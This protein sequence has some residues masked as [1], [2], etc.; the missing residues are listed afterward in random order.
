M[1]RPFTPA[2]E[3][4]G[5]DVSG[6]HDVPGIQCCDGRAAF[7]D[8][9]DLDRRCRDC[10][11]LLNADESERCEECEAIE[12]LTAQPFPFRFPTSKA[13]RD[14]AGICKHCLALGVRP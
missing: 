10:S 11:S 9:E 12:K 8:G 2:C 5:A 4:C 13:E 6:L 3:G 1:R 7:R 14:E